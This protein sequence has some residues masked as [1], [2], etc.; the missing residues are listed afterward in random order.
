MGNCSATEILLKNGASPDATDKEQM[1]PLH[2]IFLC[3][4]S[5]RLQCS[6]LLLDHGANVHSLDVWERTPLRILAGHSNAESDQD[7]LDLLV[8]RGANVN[9][10]D[11]YGQTPLLKSIQS[12][13]EATR[14]L[15]SYGADTETADMF[16]NTPLLEAVY[17]D[18]P[19]TGRLILQHHVTITEPFELQPGRRAREGPIYLLDFVL[20]YGSCAMMRVVEETLAGSPTCQLFHPTDKLCDVELIRRENGLTT[21]SEEAETFSRICSRSHPQPGSLDEAEVFFDAHERDASIC[22]A[23]DG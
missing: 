22:Y 11:I 16:G 7:V 15:L 17:R 9:C 20:W 13:L 14:L 2:D 8:K 12:T 21:T 1:T 18:K 19:E 10:R 6:R 4:L 3:P 5:S 23:A